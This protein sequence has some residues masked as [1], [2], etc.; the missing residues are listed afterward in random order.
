[1]DQNYQNEEKED[2][3]EMGDEE[4]MLK[5]GEDNDNYS[6]RKNNENKDKFA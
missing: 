6:P 1:M 3:G 4:E 2:Y 5:E